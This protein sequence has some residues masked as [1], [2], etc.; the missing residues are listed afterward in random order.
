L[1]AWEN[2][3][4]RAIRVGDWK[5]VGRAGEPWELYDL[6]ADPVELKDLASAMPEKSR[7]LAAKWD[8]WA[9]RCQVFPYPGGKGKK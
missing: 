7:E 1:L 5:L 6:A 3:R 8:E 2:E 4:N 9:K